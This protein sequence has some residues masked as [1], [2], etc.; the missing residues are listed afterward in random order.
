M[1]ID[2]NNTNFN[3]KNINSVLKKRMQIYL[4]EFDDLNKTF[5]RSDNPSNRHNSCSA[6]LACSCSEGLHGAGSQIHA[7]TSGLEEHRVHG[8]TCYNSHI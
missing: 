3:L 6:F 1:K 5:L 4:Q 7:D 2:K 8:F